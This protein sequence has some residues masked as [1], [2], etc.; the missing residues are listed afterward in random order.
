[1]KTR[2]SAATLRNF[3]LVV[4][5]IFAGLFGVIVPWRNHR[6]VPI[7][8]WALGL[9]LVASAALAPGLLRYP[10]A[11]WD[12]AGKVLGWVNSRIVLNLLFFLIFVPAGVV[13]R[14]GHW[15]PMKR[16]FKPDQ[17]TYR[18]R[19]GAVSPTTMEKPY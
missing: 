11:V 3:G 16:G 4:G 15:D 13:A 12:R 19:S 5:S 8:P 10:Y 9:T 6:T 7:W 2:A 14:L 17:S 1:L 18:I